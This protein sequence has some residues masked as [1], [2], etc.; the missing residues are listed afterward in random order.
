MSAIRIAYWVG[1][2][3]LAVLIVMLLIGFLQNPVEARRADLERRLSELSPVEPEFDLGADAKFEEWQQSV[4][5]R[6]RLWGPLI[7]PQKA[8]AAPPALQ[9]M[10]AGVEPTRNTMGSGDS[11]KVQIRV[12]GKKDWYAKGQQVK[13]CTIAEITPNDILFT[14]TQDERVHGMRLPRK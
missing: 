1:G 14:V 2:A 13:G 4:A 3:V 7:P 12:D 9:Q 10:L 5:A 11:A 8:E 6:A